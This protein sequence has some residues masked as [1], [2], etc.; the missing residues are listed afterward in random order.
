MRRFGPSDCTFS[1]SSAVED[2]KSRLKSGKPVWSLDLKSATDRLP[3]EYTLS[4]LEDLYDKDFADTWKRVMVDRPYSMPKSRKPTPSDEVYYAVGQPMG[5]LSSWSAFTLTHHAIVRMCESRSG[6]KV[7]KNYYILGDDIVLF[8]ERLAKE[9][10]D[11]MRKSGVAISI[12]KSYSPN[13]FGRSGA[14]FAKRLFTREGH[15]VSPLPLRLIKHGRPGKIAFLNEV[16]LRHC[17]LAGLKSSDLNH[18]VSRSDLVT[19]LIMFEDYSHTESV[20]NEIFKMAK[21]LDHNSRELVPFGVPS[22]TS[23]FP[24]MSLVVQAL[25]RYFEKY[26]SKLP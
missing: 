4:V 14:E 21:G 15:D 10:S 12:A 2:I 18:L 11:F 13:E 24:N 3:I 25:R 23:V 1:I 8:D 22:G 17:N 16:L 7:G 26:L 9:Y 20:W 6:L 5:T 19:A